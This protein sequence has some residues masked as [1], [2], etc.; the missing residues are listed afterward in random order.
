[1]IRW[2]RDRSSS[3][4]DAEAIEHAT[5]ESLPR[6]ANA[7]ALLIERTSQ[8]REYILFQR[9]RQPPLPPPRLVADAVAA[10]GQRDPALGES[11]LRLLADGPSA[12]AT[13]IRK[14]L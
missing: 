8:N 7:V 14:L 11:L 13:L 2:L 1:M 5:P 3:K 10:I 6:V 9:Y 12:F 4:N